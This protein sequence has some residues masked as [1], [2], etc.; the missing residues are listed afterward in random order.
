MKN[1]RVCDERAKWSTLGCDSSGKCEASREAGRSK[2]KYDRKE[3]KASE[4]SGTEQSLLGISP[5][6]Y[7]KET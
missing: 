6:G 4:G 2:E 3:K 1:F 5:P 7:S